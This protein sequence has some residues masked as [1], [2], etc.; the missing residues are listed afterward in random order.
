MNMHHEETRRTPGDDGGARSAGAEDPACGARPFKPAPWAALCVV[1]LMTG[2]AG[3]GK[4]EATDGSRAMFDG[5]SLNGWRGDPA[6]WSVQE[7]AITGTTAVSLPE[8]TFLIHDGE[9]SDFVVRLKYRFSTEAGNSG[10]QYRSRPDRE[11]PY[12]VIGYQ[13]NVV[14]QDADRSFA[15]LWEE[16]GRELLA[17]CG[18]KVVLRH[19][20]DPA[21]KGFERRVSGG[22]A[23]CEGIRAAVRPY[24]QWNDYII[25]AYKNRLVHILNGRVTIDVTDED[26]D[27]RAMTGFFA[28]QIHRGLAMRVQFTD[29]QLRPLTSQPRWETEFGVPAATP[30]P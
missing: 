29:L 9:F 2:C 13:A 11:R 30:V 12:S 3:L 18:E 23:D 21:L 14:T 19:S 6:L 4:P 20:D 28:L 22:L 27:A 25:V 17:R 1:A 16:R 7:G 10:L 5:K 15:M 8:N 24:P 26:P